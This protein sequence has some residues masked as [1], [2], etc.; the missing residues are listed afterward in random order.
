LGVHLFDR[1]ARAERLGEQHGAVDEER[2]L[3]GTSAAAPREAPQPL[4]SRIA[5]AQPAQL[6]APAPVAAG[7]AASAE[8]A[9]PTSAAKADSSR[10]ARLARTLRSTSTPALRAP[11]RKRLSAVPLA[12]HA[13]LVRW[14]QSL[15]ISPLRARRSRNE[16]CPA[17]MT[18]SFAA[19]NERLRLP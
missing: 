5:R 12:R 7:A 9:T 14:I 2:A 3:L 13:A 11:L 19:R 4:Q 8:S 6:S 18:A 16:Y 17:C 15:R 1:G 10:A